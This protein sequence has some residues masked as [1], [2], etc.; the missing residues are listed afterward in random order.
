[1]S[2]AVATSPA[3]QVQALPSFVIWA[4]YHR[5]HSMT[6]TSVASSKSI[7][8]PSSLSWISFETHRLCEAIPKIAITNS[9]ILES[10]CAT[11][12][13]RPL[14]EKAATAHT[15]PKPISNRVFR[16]PPNNHDNAGVCSVAAL[17]THNRFQMHNPKKLCASV[18][19]AITI[20][21]APIAVART[22]GLSRKLSTIVLELSRTILWQTSAFDTIATQNKSN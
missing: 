17:E 22:L 15:L 16:R 4:W 14:P 12:A 7:V 9:I 5:W 10:Y 19:T 1:M 2:G 6:N 3:T 20:K 8:I 13:G 11:L 21:A 18:A